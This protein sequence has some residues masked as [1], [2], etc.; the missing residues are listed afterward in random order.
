MGKNRKP[1]HKQ[2]GYRRVPLLA[3]TP[4][5]EEMI[6]LHAPDC[7]FVNHMGPDCTCR[8]VYKDKERK[9]DGG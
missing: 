1:S 2:K 7:E 8:A 4:S 6:V 3:K 9:G 5:G